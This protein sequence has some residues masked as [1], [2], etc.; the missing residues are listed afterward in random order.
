MPIWSWLGVAALVLCIA[1]FRQ[2]HYDISKDHEQSEM[3]AASLRNVV[4]VGGSYVGLVSRSFE[5]NRHL[6]TSSSTLDGTERSSA[7]GSSASSYPPGS[8]D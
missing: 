5:L 1:Y 2:T 8:S 3:V 6:L 4:V 7:I